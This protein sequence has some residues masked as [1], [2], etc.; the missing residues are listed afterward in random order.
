MFNEFLTRINR[1]QT[2]SPLLARMGK[3]IAST[4][5]II[6][7]FGPAATA[8]AADPLPGS[9]EDPLVTRSY[10]EHYL[11]DYYSKNYASL[12]RE[13]QELT[14]RVAQLEQELAALREQGQPGLP[15]G[16]LNITLVVNETTAYV[17][18]QPRE[19]VQPPVM[20]NDRVLLPF[21]FIGEALGARVTYLKETRQVEFRTGT[22]HLVLTL[23]SRTA[24][25]NGQEK[26]LDVA[27]RLVHGSTLVPV[28]VVSEYLGAQVDWNPQTRQV[29]IRR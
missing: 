16:Q 9:Q 8:V 13:V 5:L 6:S 14:E 11:Q 15:S 21:R 1:N 3:L 7:F 20:E 24:L 12:Q 18:G 4:I 27:P 23:D 25:V 10:L 19:L 29:I 26:Q 2:F 17:N 22:T 28:R